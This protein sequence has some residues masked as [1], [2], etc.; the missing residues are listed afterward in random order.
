MIMGIVG[1]YGGELNSGSTLLH[2]E[3]SSSV[4]NLA[5][6]TVTHFSV[7]CYF[8]NG[9]R[10]EN[11]PRPSMQSHICVLGRVIGLTLAK[12]QLA[13]AIND[14]FFL[15]S[16]IRSSLSSTS[17]ESAHSKR[18]SR[19]AGRAEPGTPSKRARTEDEDSTLLETEL[20]APDLLKG[21]REDSESR[22]TGESSVTWE[23]SPLSAGA[24][25]YELRTRQGKKQ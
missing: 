8:A 3:L 12:T 7:S 5:T 19:W 23:S 16:S 4:Y 2:F 17:P 1:H 14:V 6:R 21:E 13:I 25:T 20:P 24:G 10:W 18:A 9:R 11:F 15:P 22:E